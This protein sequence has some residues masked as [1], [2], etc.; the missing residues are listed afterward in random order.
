MAVL[1]KFKEGLSSC[2]VIEFLHQQNVSWWSGPFEGQK[3]IVPDLCECK[4]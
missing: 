3:I 4:A 2:G 1:C